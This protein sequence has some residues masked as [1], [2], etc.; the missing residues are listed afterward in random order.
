M[1]FSTFG[2]ST[3]SFASRA[4]NSRNRSVLSLMQRRPK[5]P[6]EPFSTYAKPS[7]RA[8][9][10][11]ADGMVYTETGDM[12]RFGELFEDQRTIVCFIR[13]YW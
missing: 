10:S 4:P 12:V 2:Q 13:H 7:A 1:A 8:L 3:L 9:E 6:V 5:K 11:A